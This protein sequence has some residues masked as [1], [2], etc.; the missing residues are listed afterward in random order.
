MYQD[1]EYL[2]ILHRSIRSDRS[3]MNYIHR[4]EIVP[5]DE[6]P[7]NHWFHALI[8]CKGYPTFIVNMRQGTHNFESSI[9]WL[10]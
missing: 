7:Y 8:E 2:E 5:D 6:E 10:D 9:E 1:H 3:V 4:D